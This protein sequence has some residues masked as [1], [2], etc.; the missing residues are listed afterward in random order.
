MLGDADEV[1][2]FAALRF[3]VVFFG[4]FGLLSTYRERLTPRTDLSELPQFRESGLV[5]DHVAALRSDSRVMSLLIMYGRR[6]VSM[7]AIGD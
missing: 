1:F 5:T 3:F 6:S 7:I 2:F 4:T